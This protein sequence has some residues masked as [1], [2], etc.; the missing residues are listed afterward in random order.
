MS[1]ERTVARPY[2]KAL[3]EVALAEKHLAEWSSVLQLLAQIM[4]NQ[5]AKR[6]VSNPA[7]TPTQHTQW[8]MALCGKQ[9]VHPKALE[10]WLGVLCENKRLPALPAIAVQFDALRAEQEKTVT[11]HL[12]SFM[13]LTPLE[14]EHFITALSQRLQRKVTLEVTLDPSLLGGAVIAAG[15]L[16]IDGSVRS[17]LIKLGAQ[18][19]A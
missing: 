13:P 10:N 17:K 3:F 8:L 14:E 5:D 12:R 11:A 19:A 1:D 16:V 2:A 9:S 7:T 4:L 18:L 6:W 15:D